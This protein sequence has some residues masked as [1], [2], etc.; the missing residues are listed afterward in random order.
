[1]DE[2]GRVA[3][4]FLFAEPVIWL[5]GVELTPAWLHGHLLRARLFP[6]EGGDPDWAP[7]FA[8]EQGRGGLPPTQYHPGEGRGPIGKAAVTTDRPTLLPPPNWAPAF[9][10]V[11]EFAVKAAS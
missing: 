6:R 1:M 11:A 3:S 2:R 8:G 5:Q 4:Q 9:A 7:A 10:G